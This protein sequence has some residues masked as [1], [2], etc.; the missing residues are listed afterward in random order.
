MGAAIRMHDGL[1]VAATHRFDV[2]IQHRVHQFGIWARAD[3][4]TDD[5]AVETVDHGRHVHLARRDL[6]LRDVGQPFLFG[7]GRREVALDEV[8][9]RRADLSQVGAVAPALRSGRDQALLLHQ[10]PDHL[11][12]QVQALPGQR[13]LHAA[14]A[15]ATMIALEDV[16]HGAARLGILAGHLRSRDS[17]K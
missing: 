13:S 1:V 9:G 6:E 4:P 15:I 14:A 12:G 11:L 10:E 8:V 7:S 16:C 17:N 3:R 2:R 5:L